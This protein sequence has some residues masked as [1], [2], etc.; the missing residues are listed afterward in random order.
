MKDVDSDVKDR[1]YSDPDTDVEV[2][3]PVLDDQTR[4]CKVVCEDNTVL[5]EVVPSGCKAIYL[6]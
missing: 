3:T 2:G 6:C 4:G 5:E 1:K